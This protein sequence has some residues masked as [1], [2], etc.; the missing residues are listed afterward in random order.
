MLENEIVD[1]LRFINKMFNKR[2]DILS[3]D[4][5]L[6]IIDK[7]KKDLRFNR[8]FLFGSVIF[9]TS[10]FYLALYYNLEPTVGVNYRGLV[11][12]RNNV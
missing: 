6:T 12:M 7:V 1:Q 5:I 10:L 2:Q 8:K 3:D 9:M 11:E 4:N